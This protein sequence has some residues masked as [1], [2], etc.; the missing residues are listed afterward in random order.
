MAA[1]I[2][3]ICGSFNFFTYKIT[4]KLPNAINSVG[5]SYILRIAITITDPTSAPNDC[6]RYPAHKGFN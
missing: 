2:S 4:N 5:R 1:A 3:M 6:R